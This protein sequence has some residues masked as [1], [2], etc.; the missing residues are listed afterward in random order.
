[1]GFSD[2][3]SKDM[4]RKEERLFVFPFYSVMSYMKSTI[5]STN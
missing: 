4:Q 2:F 5:T 3:A 1:M